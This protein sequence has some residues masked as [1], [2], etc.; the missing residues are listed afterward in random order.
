M[1]LILTKFHRD[2]IYF[3][4][5]N[6]PILPLSTIQNR[7]FKLFYRTFFYLFAF[8][9]I[10]FV[11]SLHAQS[12]NTEFRVFRLFNVILNRLQLESWLKV[13]KMIIQIE[14]Y[15][16]LSSHL[17]IHLESFHRLPILSFIRHWARF[18]LL[19]SHIFVRLRLCT[20]KKARLLFFAFTKDNV[21]KLS[22]RKFH[23]KSFL[24]TTAKFSG[25]LMKT[26][27]NISFTRALTSFCWTSRVIK[28]NPD[29]LFWLLDL[30]FSLYSEE[31][32]GLRGLFHIVAKKL[33]KV[34]N[35]SLG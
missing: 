12:H 15:C 13:L 8:L 17:T 5:W 28:V 35:R 25:L 3:P 34:L 21:L 9:T 10:H 19:N 11:L 20:I 27:Q 23:W 26:I 33:I 2:R 6:V 16:S 24:L 32:R 7:N 22:I 4:L 30:N 1:S 31:G 29:A 14:L 18:C